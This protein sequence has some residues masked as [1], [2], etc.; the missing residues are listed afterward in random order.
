MRAL[1]SVPSVTVEANVGFGG[2]RQQKLNGQPC[3]SY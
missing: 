1:D 3:I 2:G